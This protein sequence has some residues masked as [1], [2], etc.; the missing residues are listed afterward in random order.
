VP[1]NFS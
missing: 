1:T